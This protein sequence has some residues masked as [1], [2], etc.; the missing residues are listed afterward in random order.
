MPAHIWWLTQTEVLLLYLKLV[1]WPW[2]LVIHYDP[3]YLETVAAAWPWLLP[4]AALLILT[5]VLFWRRTSAGFVALWVL[6]VL[7]PTL[8]VPLPGETVAER[9]M[10]VPLAA[11]VP[12][13][14]VA[15]YEAIR[16]AA[17]L[18]RGKSRAA[19]SDRWP[20]ALVAC[21]FLSVA[22]A[23][24]L[25][26]AHRLSAYKDGLTILED[27][28]VH[29]PED[30]VIRNELGAELVKAGRPEEAIKHL[31]YGLRLSP[32]SAAE[33]PAALLHYNLALALERVGRIPEAMD[34]YAEAVHSLPNYAQAHYNLG[35]LFHE[36]GNH[37]EAEAH[38]R[39]ALASKPNFAPAHTNLGTLLA[40]EGRLEEAIQHLREGSRL[41]PNANAYV[42]LVDAYV[43]AGQTDDAARAAR[44]TVELARSEGHPELA[45]QIEAWLKTTHTANS[46]APARGV[47]SNEA[48]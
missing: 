3:P 48:Q 45:E 40:S 11:I 37:P 36:Y 41:H 20:I 8:L 4:V 2:P 19:A 22:L 12:L 13:V 44:E 43:L 30:Y 39:A 33:L 17:G 46:A 25:V 38:Y 21:A 5:L 42:H 35:L 24:G 26:T 32:N 31:E 6:A 18:Y 15:A 27:V 23:F 9:R 7:S 28:L 10:Y 29:Q 34:H 47:P 14:V 1:L 16:G